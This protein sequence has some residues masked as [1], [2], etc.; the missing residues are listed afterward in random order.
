MKKEPQGEDLDSSWSEMRHHCH[1]MAEQVYNYHNIL[2]AP[3][4]QVVVV[5]EAD[6]E[7]M[8]AET[9]AWKSRQLNEEEFELQKPLFRINTYTDKQVRSR[10]SYEM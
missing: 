6:P 1:L 2:N 4:Y 8:M 10:P 3:P 9:E 5:A 7:R